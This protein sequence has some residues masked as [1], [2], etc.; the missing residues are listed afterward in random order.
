MSPWQMG[1]YQHYSR[2]APGKVMSKFGTIG[3]SKMVPAPIDAGL[4]NTMKSRYA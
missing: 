3:D 4:Q 1:I 2:G